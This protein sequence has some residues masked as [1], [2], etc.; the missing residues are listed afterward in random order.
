MSF[1]GWKINMEKLLSMISEAFANQPL[2]LHLVAM[3]GLVSFI[4]L[5]VRAGRVSGG[6]SDRKIG[7]QAIKCSLV[8]LA[9]TLVGFVGMN[10][11]GMPYEGFPM[12][13][14]PEDQNLLPILGL[15]AIPLV[16]IL[17]EGK[18]YVTDAL[19][20][21]REEREKKQAAQELAHQLE[22]RAKAYA[23]EF[24]EDFEDSGKEETF[25]VLAVSETSWGNVYAGN[26]IT[27]YIPDGRTIHLRK[28]QDDL[29][30]ARLMRKLDQIIAA[31]DIPLVEARARISRIKEDGKVVIHE[32]PRAIALF[33]PGYGSKIRG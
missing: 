25:G 26:V 6:L 19:Q 4:Y 1:L 31:G 17:R 9:G 12:Q 16:L 15:F 7:K 5:I 10:E 30:F 27:G 29:N 3:I 33:D 20:G 8:T 23:E 13:V 18:G 28:D 2:D 32:S 11:L 14:G 21:L 22:N 24:G